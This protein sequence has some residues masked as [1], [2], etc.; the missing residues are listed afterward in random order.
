MYNAEL[1]VGRAKASVGR[2]SS[3]F[4]IV[5][6]IRIFGGNTVR[7]K[8]YGRHLASVIVNDT[9]PAN[10]KEPP[11]QCYHLASQLTET[12]VNFNR[13]PLTIYKSHFRP[14]YKILWSSITFVQ[15]ELNLC[16]GSPDVSSCP[17]GSVLH[18]WWL[19]SAAT[20]GY[21]QI[22]ISTQ[23]VNN[24]KNIRPVIIQT[25]YVDGTP[26]SEVTPFTIWYIHPPHQGYP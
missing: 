1:G 11:Y 26:T 7:T 17:K 3:Q 23:S 20:C 13:S 24:S 19:H 25:R 2:V 21:K 22:T 10:S 16:L 15:S 9:L 6:T 14:C 4:C 12:Y 5:C 8:N 18:L